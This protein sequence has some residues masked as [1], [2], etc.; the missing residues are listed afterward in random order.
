MSLP[1]RAGILDGSMSREDVELVRRSYAAVANREWDAAMEA[2]APDTVWDD[3]DLRPEGA[4]RRGAD[5]MRAE[6]RAWF[7]TWTDYSWDL[8][9]LIDAG[10][11]VVVVIGHERGRGKG[12]GVMM[13]Q[14]VGMVVT[15]R[16]GSIVHTKVFRDPADALEA[17][18]PTGEDGR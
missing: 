10:D 18:G 6:M 12:S 3:S 4:V 8:E 16:H 15:V 17:V 14:R 13:D 2:Y 11:G 9:R 5:A 7:G 1:S